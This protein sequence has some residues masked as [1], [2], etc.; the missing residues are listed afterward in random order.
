L[1]LLKDI[2]KKVF[3]LSFTSINDEFNE[4][5]LAVFRYQFENCLI[6]RA[7][8]LGLKIDVNAIK[9]YT[10]IP[11]LPIEFFKTQEISCGKIHPNVVR[12][13]SSGTTGQITSTHYVTDISIYESSFRK[14]FEAFYGDPSNYCILAL[15]PN[16][17]ERK[18]SSLVYMFD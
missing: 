16:Y 5:A 14:G 13:S 6:Y 10:E 4:I 12:F 3:E 8:V 17:L 2:Q 7:Y 15:L 9:R 1:L 18:G 11:F